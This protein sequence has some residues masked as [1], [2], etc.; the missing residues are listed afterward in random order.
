MINVEID[1]VYEFRKPREEIVTMDRSW[2]LKAADEIAGLR[3]ELKFMTKAVEAS[4]NDSRYF[5]VKWKELL[6]QEPN[7]IRSA[8]L[9]ILEELQKDV[10]PHDFA[11]VFIDSMI[12]ERKDK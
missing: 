9:K 2:L 10:S 5:E 12:E 6:E 8:E 4:N 1:L 11:S 7:K 3:S